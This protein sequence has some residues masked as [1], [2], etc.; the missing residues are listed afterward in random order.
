MK[1]KLICMSDTHGQHEKLT[2]LIKKEIEITPQDV[3]VILIHC[4]D[5]SINGR[6]E[7]HKEFLRWKS[8][9]EKETDTFFIF[10]QGNHDYNFGTLD[11]YSLGRWLNLKFLFLNKG[12]YKNIFPQNNFLAFNEKIEIDED[13]K[14]DIDIMI[15]HQPAFGICDEVSTSYGTKSAGSKEIKELLE[16]VKPKIFLFGHI[17]DRSGK[18][19]NYKNIQCYNVSCLGGSHNRKTMYQM[20]E[21]PLTIINYEK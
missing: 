14:K 15:S 13:D 5:Y 8:Y 17:H 18:N 20:R 6:E 16:E 1:Y 9:L 10:I 11:N 3:K 7:E 4:G 21:N 2:D 12:Y 19:T